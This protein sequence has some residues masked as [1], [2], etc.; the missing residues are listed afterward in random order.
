MCLTIGLQRRALNHEARI[1]DMITA[2]FV[3]RFYSWP[4][5]EAGE[6]MTSGRKTPGPTPARGQTT[7]PLACT[8][9]TRGSA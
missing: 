3:V 7:S 9:S 4:P 5:A 1:T 2:A 8:D 6:Q